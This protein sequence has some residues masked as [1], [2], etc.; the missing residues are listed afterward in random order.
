ME[1]NL[2]ET[3]FVGDQKFVFRLCHRADVE[4]GLVTVDQWW[5]PVTKLYSQRQSRTHRSGNQQS[6][7]DFY[8]ARCCEEAATD[9]R[10]VQER[11][12]LISLLPQMRSQGSRRILLDA[13]PPRGTLQDRGA[14]VV[15][16]EHLLKSQAHTRLSW[17]GFRQQ[18]KSYL[19]P[20]TVYSEEQKEMYF[21]FVDSLL[22]EACDRLARGDP[23]G[24]IGVAGFHWSRVTKLYGRRAGHQEFKLLLDI[25]SYEGRAALHHA[26]S[27]VWLHLI[28]KLQEHHRISSKTMA[29]LQFWHLDWIKP[30]W[31]TL[32]GCHSLFH[33]HVFALHP[34]CG[35]FLQTQTGQELLGAWIRD[36]RR[37][38]A[39]ECLLN[40]L[41]NAILHYRCRYEQA[42]SAREGWN[43]QG[44]ADIEGLQAQVQRDRSGRRRLPGPRHDD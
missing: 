20:E 1:S 14:D 7:L 2:Q 5:M 35:P 19:M 23:D 4:L 32:Q 21:G 13:F 36:R 37:E 11:Y 26:Y 16:L 15:E 44:T 24:A 10:D 39:L 34:G 41:A 43:L 33:G 9:L 27:H 29:F 42:S 40:G 22:N 6:I 38:D 18:T 30:E 31:S 25:L 17:D 12:L 28:P 3:L 8:W